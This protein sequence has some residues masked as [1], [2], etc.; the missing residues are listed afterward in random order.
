MIL[1]SLKNRRRHFLSPACRENIAIS[2]PI[3][4][5]CMIDDRSVT[6]TGPMFQLL[7]RLKSS[8]IV[9]LLLGVSLSVGSAGIFA[10]APAQ[11][12]ERIRLRYGPFERYVTRQELETYAETGVA[13]GG[14]QDVLARVGSQADL[15]QTALNANY[16]LDPVLANRFSYTTSG[17][18][19]LTEV[20]NL[21]RTESGRNG[22]QALRSALTLAAADP[23]GLNLLTFLEHF[24]SEMSIDIGQALGLAEDVGRLLGETQQVVGQLSAQTAEMAASEPAVDF[25][26]LPDPRLMGER[27]VEM[28]TLEFVDEGRD[29]TLT[30]DLYLPTATPDDSLPVI[31]VSNGLGAN[32]DRFKD[33]ASHLAS[34]GF[35]VVLPDHP[36]SD[37]QRLQDF[38]NGLNAENFE[39][40][41][42]LDRPKDITFILDEL[43]RRNSQQFKNRLNPENAGVFGYSFGGTTALALAGAQID[44]AHLQ[45]SCETR[46]SLF[47]ISLLYQCRALE[48]DESIVASTDLKDDRVKAIYTFVPFSR[49]LYGPEGIAQVEGPVLWEATDQDILTPFVVEQLPAYTWL[50]SPQNES[51]SSSAENRY[52]VITSGLPHARI[53]FEVLNRI[54]N[55]SPTDWDNIRPIAESYHH[56]LGTAFFQVHLANNETYRPYLQASGAQHLT[57]LPYPLTWTQS[58]SSTE[59]T[60]N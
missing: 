53:T 9:S 8:R 56:M 33:M 35:A 60:S 57:Q 3:T 44:L 28:Q 10:T 30:L 47:N 26:A 25:S 29:R 12:A 43:T 27:D 42:Y 20:G 24:P 1:N 38:Y 48:L 37:R 39:P 59:P 46:S 31:V 36:G 23:D 13:E 52:L 15:L 6:D 16:N 32:R 40:T 22:S 51:P 7:S 4:D 11:A 54:T 34:H 2:Q 17:E 5:L 45:E 21:I 41:E 19:L 18:Q 50:T 49:S 14:L 58:I 55:Q